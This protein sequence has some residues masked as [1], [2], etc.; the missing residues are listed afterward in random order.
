[1][2][3]K[4]EKCSIE[5][6]KN[7]SE[8]DDKKAPRFVIASSD[9]IQ[10][11][12]PKEESPAVSCLITQV[13]TILANWTSRVVDCFSRLLRVKLF[14]LVG[15]SRINYSCGENYFHIVLNHFSPDD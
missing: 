7:A 5:R 12:V 15:D 4:K 10:S 13:T 9:R 14:Y 2:D 1:M 3:F 11:T 6:R 8:D